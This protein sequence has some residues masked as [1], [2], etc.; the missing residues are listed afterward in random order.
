MKIIFFLAAITCGLTILGLLCM[1]VLVY[2]GYMDSHFFLSQFA[3]LPLL[4]AV[5]LAI[6][7]RISREKNLFKSCKK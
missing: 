3:S 5:S 4:S 6:A 2:L 7:E 1:L